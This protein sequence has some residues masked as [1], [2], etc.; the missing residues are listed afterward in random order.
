MTRPISAGVSCGARKASASASR[1]A[2]GNSTWSLIKLNGLLARAM[3]SRQSW[4]K[5]S[6]APWSMSQSLPC[7]TSMLVLRAVRSR[8]LTN[9][10]NQTMRE[11]RSAS[12]WNDSGSKVTEPGR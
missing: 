9:A 2:H 8:L 10:S 12:G 11:A 3:K 6:A 5:Y 4:W 7:H 1:L